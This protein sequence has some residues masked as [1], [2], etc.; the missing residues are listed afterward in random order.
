MDGLGGGRT[1]IL[2][3]AGRG[4]GVISVLIAAVGIA[5]TVL[6][7]VLTAAIAAR[8]EGRRQAVAERQQ[9][10]QELTQQDSQL[11]EL[12]LEH[13]RWRRERR[14]SVYLDLLTAISAAD[15][16]DQQYFREL[17]TA[18]APVAVDEARLA[19]IRSLFK[20]TEQVYYLVALEGP[21]SVAEVGQR[22]IQQ[23]GALVRDVRG[24]AEAHAQAAADLDERRGIVEAAGS[25]FMTA[26]REF[27]EAARAALDE[28]VGAP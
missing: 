17:D 21:T 25:A 7:T 3:G 27:L 22:L 8:A 2:V 13:L 5:G 4:F 28:I 15:R 1:R 9:V 10:R 6:G 11:R 14:Q 12:R 23:L 18:P 20:D 19:A 24:F 16:A 26:Q